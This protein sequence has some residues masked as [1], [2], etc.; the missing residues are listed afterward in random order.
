MQ[1][2]GV[3]SIYQ[4]EQLTAQN[5]A[6]KNGCLVD[7]NILISVSLPI[8]PKNSAAE[9]LVQRLA[10]L[11]IPL[12]SNV[13]I[14]AEFL[15]IQRRVLIPETLIEFYESNSEGLDEVLTAKLRSIQSSYR[16]AI[17]NR[18]VYKFSDDRIKEL[19]T[20]LSTYSFGDKN[21]W[22]Y[23]CENF[24]AP[25][26]GSVWDEVVHI[27]RLNFIKIRDGEMNPLL[28][29]KVSWDGVT[30][31]MGKYGLGSADSMILNLLLSSKLEIVATADGDIQYI[32]DSL[33]DQ[34]KFVLEI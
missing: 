2:L 20:L 7:T 21:A 33:K 30:H 29:S 1:D 24:L 5:E 16:E 8:D 12:Y 10:D 25:Q 9:D 22:E 3:I 32:A 34:G 18:K 15:E 28:T 31:I 23:F 17:K 19:R 4:L 6:F 14:R 11:K 27:C 26:L 13:N